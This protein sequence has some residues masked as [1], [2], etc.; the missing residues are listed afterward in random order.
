MLSDHLSQVLKSRT[1]LKKEFLLRA[2]H[3]SQDIYF[4]E[5]GLFRCFYKK[6]DVEV[7]SWFM[8]EGDVIISVESFFDQIE[9]K[10]S[11]QALEESVVYFITFRELDF[12]YKTFTE[13]NYNGRVLV[14]A[15]YKQSEQRLYSLR[16]HRAYDRYAF[17]L[18][19]YPELIQRVPAKYIASYLG[20]EETT[21]SKIKKTKKK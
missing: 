4:I 18:Q 6:N 19:N 2:G 11:I 7:S 8:K 3:V 21:L 20:I 5:Q 12:I 14:Q 1:V 9:S 17:L 13:F 16:M 10:E 15:Y